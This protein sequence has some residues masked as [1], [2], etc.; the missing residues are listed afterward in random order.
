MKG[1]AAVGMVAGQLHL[2]GGH[3]IVANLRRFPLHHRRARS[4]S[5]GGVP[6]TRRGNLVSV[7]G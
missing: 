5:S 6:R 4:P 2:P 7:L 3:R 1:T